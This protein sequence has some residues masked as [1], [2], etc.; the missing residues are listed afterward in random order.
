MAVVLLLLLCWINL[1]GVRNL[2]RWIDGLTWWKIFVPLGVAVTLM[3]LSG[4][5]SNLVFLWLESTVP[6][7]FRP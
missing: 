6:M 3:C 7:W 4:H 1:N 5:W 2:A